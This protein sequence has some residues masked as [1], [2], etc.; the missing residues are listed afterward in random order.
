MAKASC[1]QLSKEVSFAIIGLI[2]CGKYFAVVSPIL[3]AW[4]L[5]SQT[6]LSKKHSIV[7]GEEKII[8]AFLG[9]INLESYFL[10]TVS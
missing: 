4:K 10:Q 1:I 5:S 7:E 3:I 2:F 9:K 8:I 6:T